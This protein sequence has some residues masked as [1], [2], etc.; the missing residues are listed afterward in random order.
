M[1]AVQKSTRTTV[2]F[3]PALCYNTEGKRT[4]RRGKS[5]HTQWTKATTKDC[6]ELTSQ[7][8]EAHKSPKKIC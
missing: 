4:R 8:V 2:C 1:H 5:R 6:F 3:L 7:R